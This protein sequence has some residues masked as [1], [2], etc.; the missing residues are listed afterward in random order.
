MKETFLFQTFCQTFAR[1]HMGKHSMVRNEKLQVVK[2]SLSE[3]RNDRNDRWV[4]STNP[5]CNILRSESVLF[6][7]L[8]SGW[9]EAI[10][11]FKCNFKAL[12]QRLFWQQSWRVETRRP[13]EGE[14]KYMWRNMETRGLRTERPTV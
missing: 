10:L 9:W 13:K 5:F 4:Q 7:F 1:W 8:H 6:V 11:I 12:L 14:G 3:D 2:Y